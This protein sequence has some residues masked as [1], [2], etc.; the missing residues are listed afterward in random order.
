MKFSVITLFPRIVEA[1]AAEGLLAQARERGLLALETVNPRQFTEDVHQTVDDRTFGGGDGM[2]MKVEPLARAVATLEPG[3]RVVVLSPQ[4]RLWQQSE[5]A[6]W[7]KEGRPVAFVCGR[8]AGIDHR[9]TV[10]YADDEISIGDYVLNG[11]EVAACAIIESVARLIPGVLGNA[12]SAARDS[13]SE[14]LLECPQF[15]RPREVEGMS[16]PA[17]LLSGHHAKINEFEN[18]V[19]LVRTALFRPDLLSAEAELQP[20]V[21]VVGAL[22]DNELYALGLTREDLKE[23]Q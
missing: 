3:T 1:F 14:R 4:G 12:V 16:V 2:V 8:Y 7:A 15:T 19:A 13:F 10:K 20:A 11:G 17:P 23:L 18:S 5:A 21:K 22:N 6:A 9:F